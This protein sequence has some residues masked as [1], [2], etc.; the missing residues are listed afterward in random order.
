M[1]NHD[2]IRLPCHEPCTPTDRLAR[3]RAGAA[4]ER[5]EYQQVILQPSLPSRF[6]LTDL[7]AR[8]GPGWTPHF[9]SWNVFSAVFRY[10]KRLVIRRCKNVIIQPSIPELRKPHE[11]SI[12]QSSGHT[13][14]YSIT[15]TS[16][17]VSTQ[18]SPLEST[19]IMSTCGGRCP[20]SFCAA[21]SRMCAPEI[22]SMPPTEDRYHRFMD[23]Q[24]TKQGMR[25]ACSYLR[26]PVGTLR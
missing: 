13:A 21:N 15:A 6:G 14:R 2:R 26:L 8:C 19:L 10:T 17:L 3:M 23:R 1:A 24:W 22:G 16:T 11:S 25:T 7:N 18:N 20:S 12:R 5:W 4:T 9:G